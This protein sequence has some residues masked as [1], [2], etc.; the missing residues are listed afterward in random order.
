MSTTNLVLD[1]EGFV[2][3]RN[4]GL[5]TLSTNLAAG[6]MILR[7]NVYQLPAPRLIPLTPEARRRLFL[8]RT[9]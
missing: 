3:A 6:A 1:H 8:A 2:V 7:P 5:R 9:A 4:V